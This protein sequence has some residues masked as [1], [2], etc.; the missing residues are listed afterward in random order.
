MTDWHK[1]LLLF[2]INSQPVSIL[3]AIPSI[4]FIRKIANNY[5]AILIHKSHKNISIGIAVEKLKNAGLMDYFLSISL[6]TIFFLTPPFSFKEN[7]ILP[8]EFLKYYA[9]LFIRLILLVFLLAPSQ[10][11]YFKSNKPAKKSF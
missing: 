6:I 2:S 7:L 5:V 11:K 8:A 10:L 4:F 3:A 9:I 1:F